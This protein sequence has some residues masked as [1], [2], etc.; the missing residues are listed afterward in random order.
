MCMLHFFGTNSSLISHIIC[1]GEGMS[2][3]GTNNNLL[4]RDLSYQITFV[5]FIVY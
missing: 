1:R 4:S 3:E 2:G 5:A